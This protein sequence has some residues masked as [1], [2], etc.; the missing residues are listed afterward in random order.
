M[1]VKCSPDFVEQPGSRLQTDCKF[2]MFSF[3]NRD[4]PLVAKALRA[5]L[6][7]SKNEPSEEARAWQGLRGSK[8]FVRRGVGQHIVSGWLWIIEWYA[9]FIW[10]SGLF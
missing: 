6:S 5:R 9:L 4:P 2:P 8:G 7:V 3:L 1:H 10:A